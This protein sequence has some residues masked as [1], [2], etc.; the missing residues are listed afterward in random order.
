LYSPFVFFWLGAAKNMKGYVLRKEF[1]DGPQKTVDLYFTSDP[2]MAMYWECQKDADMNCRIFDAFLS[3]L[4]TSLGG[5]HTQRG[6]QSEEL[7]KDR[8]V[9]F[10]DAPFVVRAAFNP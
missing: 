9:V 2:E 10:V 7:R 1:V 6:F 5:S 4:R 8:F 3:P